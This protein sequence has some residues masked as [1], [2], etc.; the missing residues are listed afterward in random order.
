[1][2]S[3]RLKLSEDLQV[4]RNGRYNKICSFH[5]QDKT[6]S[7]SFVCWIP[8]LFCYVAPVTVDNLP[9]RVKVGMSVCMQGEG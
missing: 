7:R 1:M 3:K 9:V 8:V 5:T 2:P 6:V 4:K